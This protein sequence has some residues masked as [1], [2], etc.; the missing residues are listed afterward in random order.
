MSSATADIILDRLR[1]AGGRVTQSRRLVVQ[2]ILERG[3]HHVTAPDVLDAV[4]RTDPEF[5][6]STVYR[7]L[8]RLSELGIVEPIQLNAGATVFH[9]VQRPHHHLLCVECGT[10]TETDVKLLD[11]IAEQVAHDHGFV[12]RIDA[13]TTLHGVCARCRRRRRGGRS[14]A[15]RPA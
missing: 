4:R 15:L 14:A 13:A 8:E 7:T 12:L 11:A 10:V 1:E 3:D 9:L 6:E 5:Q 2:A